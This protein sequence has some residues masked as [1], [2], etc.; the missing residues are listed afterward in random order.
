M[1]I[2]TLTSTDSLDITGRGRVWMVTLE[3]G[4]QLPPAW[5]TRGSLVSFNGVLSEVRLSEW[6]VGL[7]GYC[8]PKVGLVVSPLFFASLDSFT[9]PRGEGRPRLCVYTVANPTTVPSRDALSYLMGQTV[10]I[11]GVERKVYGVESYALGG[12]YMAGRPIGLA[13]EEDDV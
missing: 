5:L 6:S 2:P 8:S 1:T 9:L 11:D 3:G 12:A 4:R 10:L 7:G 13:V